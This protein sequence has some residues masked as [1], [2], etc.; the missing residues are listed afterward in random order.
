[1][2]H[3]QH[4]ELGPGVDSVAHGHFR[5]MEEAIAASPRLGPTAPA[6]GRRSPIP[7]RESD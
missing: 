5:T 2:V 1:M 3:V 6:T 4:L 7:K